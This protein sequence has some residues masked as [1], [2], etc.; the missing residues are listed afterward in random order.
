[1]WALFG[2]TAEVGSR[3]ELHAAVAGN[4]SHGK[5]LAACEIRE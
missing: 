1:M 5:Y 2:R 4:E 3:T